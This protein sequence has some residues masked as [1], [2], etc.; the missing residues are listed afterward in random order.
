MSQGPYRRI[1]NRIAVQGLCAGS[2]TFGDCIDLARAEAVTVGTAVIA[3]AMAARGLTL[4]QVRDAVVNGFTRNLEALDIGCRHG[5]SNLMGAVGAE[6]TGARR[7]PLTGHALLDKAVAYTL[8]AQIGNHE[9]GLQPCAGTGDACTYSGLMRA[10]QEE[11]EDRET[12]VGAAAVML[13]LGTLFR[14]GKSTTGC[15]MEGFGAGAAASAAA[16]TEIAGGTAEAVARAVVLALSPTIAVPCTPRVMVPGLCATHIGGGVMIGWLASRLA[17]GTGLPVTVPVDIMMALAAA[18]HPISARTV[19]PQVVRHMAP[20]FQSRAEVEALVPD[21]ERTRQQIENQAVLVEARGRIR[22]LAR[23]ARSIVDPFAPAVVGGSSQA[24]GSPV[25]TARLTHY[26]ARGR[27]RQVT[28]ALGPELFARRAINVPGILAAAAFGSA[29]DDL[30]AQT[31]IFSRLVQDG[32]T[33]TL[34]R[35]EEAGLQRITIHADQGDAMV[36]ALNR[37]GGRIHLLEAYP[38]LAEAHQR[39]IA[40]GIEVAV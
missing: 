28:I 3:E 8:A 19:V 34:S 2:L 27:I 39:A 23:R 21:G 15:N 40:L 30:A 7:P 1:Q 35:A 38:S 4:E 20:F 25:N 33:V 36:A 11:I 17:C 6:L 22:E 18:V 9:I 16:F 31:G 5:R 37:G 12:I 10:M 32:T 13:K 26:L 29:T 14:E 24:V